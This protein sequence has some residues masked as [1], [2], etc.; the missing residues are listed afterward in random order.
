VAEE[1]V[2][3]E[4]HGDVLAVILQSVGTRNALTPAIEAGLVEGIAAAR[5]PRVRAVLLTGRG[6]AF[7]AGAN[8]SELEVNADRDL[9]TLRVRARELPE[10]ILRPIVELEK[11]V[12]VGIN[13]AAAGAGIGLA[14]AGDFRVG[15]ASTRFLFA[16]RRI[17]LAPDLGTCWSLP[18]LVGFRT[19]RDLLYFGRTVAADEAFAI[20]LLDRLCADDELWDASLELATE[21]AAGPTVALGFTK[22][23]L[24]R[25]FELGLDDLVTQEVMAQTTLVNGEDHREG[26]AA[27]RER[28]DPNFQ[29]R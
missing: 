2:A 19:A 1:A 27:F 22:L 3:I 14:L 24:R 28:R 26:V 15:S 20:G 9:A 16:F 13:G 11:P 8:M 29:G 18:R 17:A 23:M 12:V 25:A 21:L 4:R 5:D 7:C 6:P 10:A